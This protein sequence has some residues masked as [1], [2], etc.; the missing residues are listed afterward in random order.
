MRIR[1]LAVL[2]GAV[3]LSTACRTTSTTSTTLSGTPVLTQVPAP[4]PAVDPVG[5]WSL[6]LVAQGQNL[7]LTMEVER[8]SGND[9]KGTISSDM[10]P[11]M[12]FTNATLDGNRMVITAP[13]PTGDMATLDLRFNGD[14]IDGEWSMP[15]DGSK[16]SGKRM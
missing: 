7:G 16:V 6:A 10:F 14:L 5:R 11:P 8:I 9:F 15:G 12:A 4:A 2:A 3:L 13:S 1:T